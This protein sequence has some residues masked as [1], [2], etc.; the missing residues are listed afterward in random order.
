MAKKNFR[1]KGF[2]SAYNSE[3]ITEHKLRMSAAYW[4]TIHG[5][6]SLLS[7]TTQHPQRWHPQLFGPSHLNSSGKCPTDLLA[8][9]LLV[10]FS[11]LRFVSPGNASSCQV[12]RKTNQDCEEKV[13]LA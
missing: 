2:I 6:L 10:A 12:E 7:H 13:Y 3:S 8:G 11:Q 5:L 9:Y 1:G 4:V